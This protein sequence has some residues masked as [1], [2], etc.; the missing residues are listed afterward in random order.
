[1]E[2]PPRGCPLFGP[3]GWSGPPVGGLELTVATF[4]DLIAFKKRSRAA[5]MALRAL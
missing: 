5:K 4:G 1:M 2:H 3:A